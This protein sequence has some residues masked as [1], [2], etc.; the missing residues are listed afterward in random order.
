MIRLSGFF[1]DNCKLSGV[2]G[3][4]AN[5]AQREAQLIP[6]LSGICNAALIPDSYRD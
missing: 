2:E 6:R 1:L 5:A 3:G 4:I